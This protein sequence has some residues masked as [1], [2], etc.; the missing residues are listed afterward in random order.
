MAEPLAKIIFRFLNR[1]FFFSDIDECS[2]DSSPCDD[3][4]DCTNSDGSY[5]CTCKQG[6]SGNGVV[7]TGGLMFFLNETMFHVVKGRWHSRW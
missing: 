4:A 2:V 5:S 6:F 7:C 1:F 3:N